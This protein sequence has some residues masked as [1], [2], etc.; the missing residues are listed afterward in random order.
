M[1]QLTG[2]LLLGG[3][4]VLCRLDSVGPFTSQESGMNRREVLTA[5]GLAGAAALATPV[6]G[7]EQPSAAGITVDVPPSSI[8]VLRD[9][10][11]INL[12]TADGF[13]LHAGV[14]AGAPDEI[15]RGLRAP[16]S[17]AGRVKLMTP[18]VGGCAGGGPRWQ[19]QRVGC[20]NHLYPRMTW[21]IPHSSSVRFTITLL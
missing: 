19:T 17:L 8:D 15:P 13:S 20:L 5:S 7:R 21:G 1:P 4:T 11:P 12:A 18:G 10:P 9:G 3:E 16:Q 6:A 14:A 2:F